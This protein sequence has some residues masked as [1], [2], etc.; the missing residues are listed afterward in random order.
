MRVDI[1]VCNVGIWKLI[2][3]WF[4][5]VM[6]IT[7]WIW[8]H[9]SGICGYISCNVRKIPAR[10]KHISADVP[11]N[12]QLVDLNYEL[13]YQVQYKELNGPMQVH[14]KRRTNRKSGFITCV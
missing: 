13:E 11:S 1:I 7:K 8:Y 3:K 5:F 12:V 10:F 2:K 14:F 9:E 4:I 6:Y